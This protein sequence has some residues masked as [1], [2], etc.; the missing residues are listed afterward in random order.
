[1]YYKKLLIVKQNFQLK[2][3][4]VVK[5]NYTVVSIFEDL[6]DNPNPNLKS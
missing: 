1:M 4:E 2:N 3:I 5:K 6:S